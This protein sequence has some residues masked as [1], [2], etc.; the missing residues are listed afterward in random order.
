MRLRTFLGG[1]RTGRMLSILVLALFVLLCGLHIA[2]AHHDSHGD[3]FGVAA[4][5]F[6]LLIMVGLLMLRA[7]VRPA[8]DGSYVAAGSD[9][10]DTPPPGRMGSGLSPQGAPLLC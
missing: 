3:G 8:L 5:A 6:V 2:G 9:R 7:L 4:E 1:T 10:P